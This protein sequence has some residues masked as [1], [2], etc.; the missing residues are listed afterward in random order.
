MN[1]LG[2]S[3]SLIQQNECFLGVSLR[4]TPHLHD[5]SLVVLV[6]GFLSPAPGF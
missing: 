3:M 6:S 5:V 1:L 2:T 4:A